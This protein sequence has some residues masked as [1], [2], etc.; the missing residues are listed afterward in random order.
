MK[1]RLMPRCGEGKDLPL[2]SVETKNSATTGSE[3]LKKKFDFR[4]HCFPRPDP[5]SDALIERARTSCVFRST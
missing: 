2:N 3:S 4:G 5:D 1:K